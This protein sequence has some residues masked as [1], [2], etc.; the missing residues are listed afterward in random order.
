MGSEWIDDVG[1]GW[2][3]DVGNDLIFVRGSGSIFV[4]G[5]GSIS[6]RVRGLTVF[7]ATGSFVLDAWEAI[8]SL[9][10]AWI[11]SLPWFLNSMELQ[12]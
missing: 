2:I 9:I 8:W 12:E 1:S 4:R 5:S 6:V 10:E 11:W 7:V 3:D